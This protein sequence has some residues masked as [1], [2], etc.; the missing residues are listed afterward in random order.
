MTHGAHSPYTIEEKNNYEPIK[1]FK[2]GRT[3]LD[4]PALKIN[5]NTVIYILNI[6][7][8]FPNNIQWIAED[9]INGFNAEFITGGIDGFISVEG[10]SIPLVYEVSYQ[11]G[12]PY[13]V[14]RKSCKS[15]M[16]EKVLSSKIKTITT[17]KQQEVYLDNK[18]LINIVNKRLMFIDDVISSGATLRACEKI[19]NMAGGE[20]IGCAT[21][22]IEGDYV[23]KI[24]TYSLVRLPIIKLTKE[25]GEE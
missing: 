23:T 6:M 18:D 12:L 21:M 9:L 4:L 5:N 25:E 15:Y 24:P 10:K 8:G 1:A 20:I 7:G 2:F 14:L 13:T 16:G 11:T 3:T 19:V 17:D 22:A